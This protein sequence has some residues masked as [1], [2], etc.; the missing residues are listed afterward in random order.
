MGSDN[1][2]IWFLYK[3]VDAVSDPIC[4]EKWIPVPKKNHT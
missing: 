1:G 3:K 4:A 2:F